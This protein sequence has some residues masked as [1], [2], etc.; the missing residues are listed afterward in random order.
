[1]DKNAFIGK[2]W[3]FP[4]TFVKGYNTVVMTEDIQN[5]NENLRALFST[6]LGE[7]PFNQGYGTRLKNFVFNAQSALLEIEIKDALTTAIKLYEP[8]IIV[9]NLVIDMTKSADGYVS[10]NLQYTVR[11]INSRHNFVYP[12]YINEGTHLDI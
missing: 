5:V 9:D 3:G 1:M 11:Q 8:R 6:T 7:R 4:P 10:V 2:G 12:F